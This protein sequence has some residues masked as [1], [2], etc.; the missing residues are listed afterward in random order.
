MTLKDKL[1]KCMRFMAILK[2]AIAKQYNVRHIA[3]HR[4]QLVIIFIA[5][6]LVNN[7]HMMDEIERTDNQQIPRLAEIRSKGVVFIYAL[8]GC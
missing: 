7:E 3:T 1:T 4:L 2:R 6:K 5:R 8:C